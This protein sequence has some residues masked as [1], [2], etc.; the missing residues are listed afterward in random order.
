MM[1][2]TIDT[3]LF[4][5]YFCDMHVPIVEIKQRAHQVQ[6]KFKKNFFEFFGYIKNFKKRNF[7]LKKFFRLF[8]GRYSSNARLYASYSGT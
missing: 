6:R 4:T 7:F 5:N 2:A 8:L 3:T 1:S